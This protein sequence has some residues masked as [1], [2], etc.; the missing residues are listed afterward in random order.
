M[1]NGEKQQELGGKG[2]HSISVDLAMN[3]SPSQ[4]F[5]MPT[6]MKAGLP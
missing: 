1:L 4:Y 3:F 5:G 6:S 2:N